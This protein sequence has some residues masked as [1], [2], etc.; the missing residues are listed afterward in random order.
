MDRLRRR[1]HREWLTH[2]VVLVTSRRQSNPP[3]VSLRH[4]P[5]TRLASGYRF[6]FEHHLSFTTGRRQRNS[7]TGKTGLRA[8]ALSLDLGRMI[9]QS[10]EVP[11]V[12]TDLGMPYVDGRQVASAVKQASSS[13]PVI[14]LT[15]WG[16]RTADEG[17]LPAHVD[18]VLSKP[19]KRRDLNAALVQW[20]RAAH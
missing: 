3:Q 10:I 13:T 1:R 20:C 7:R 12:I 19:P 2:F 5:G 8:S 6:S 15:G 9:M 18:H 17:D 4:S 16:Q 14:M 11:V